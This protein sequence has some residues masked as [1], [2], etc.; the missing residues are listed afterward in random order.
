M[1][2]LVALDE[3]RLASRGQ[4]TLTL[5]RAERRNAL[6]RQMLHDLIAALA[7]IEQHSKVR[8][9]VL[10][11]TGPV[12]CAGM[13]LGEMQAHAH[14]PDKEQQWQLDSELYAEVLSRLFRLPFPTVAQVQGPVLAGGVGLILACDFVLSSHAAF[15]ALPEPVR[16]ITAA[17][18]T[19]FLIYRIG[20]GSAGQ[21]LL[22]GQRLTAEQAQ[23]SGLGFWVGEPEQLEGQVEQLTTSILTGAPT[24]L[25]I[26][27]R[28][29][30]NCTQAAAVLQQ[31]QESIRVSAEARQSPDARE[32]LA[33]FLEKRSPLWSV[34]QQTTNR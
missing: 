32:G 2:E 19:P 25:A 11:S 6:T 10:K 27:K 8:V 12:F 20:A 13:D 15:F 4:V 16:G 17:I 23:R 3:S 22:A 28:H 9:L 14:A 5:L 29:W 18:V 7:M 30:H 34:E 24:A 31:A 21:W 1:S 33:A 26:T